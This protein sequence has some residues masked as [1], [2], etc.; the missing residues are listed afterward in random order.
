MLFRTD[1]DYSRVRQANHEQP[2]TSGCLALLRVGGRT[3]AVQHLRSSPEIGFG[4]A[5]GLNGDDRS[6]LES[7]GHRS[8]RPMT[9]QRRGWGV[10]SEVLREARI[11][12]ALLPPPKLQ[13]VLLLLQGSEGHNQGP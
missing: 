2:N 6:E 12:H 5:L 8:H 4:Q 7:G 3:P 1:R 13:I 10:F 11:R 9:G